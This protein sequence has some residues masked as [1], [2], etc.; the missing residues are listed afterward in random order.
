MHK[1]IKGVLF[2]TIFFGVAAIA[3]AE[4][5]ASVQTGGSTASGSAIPP[6]PEL[7]INNFYNFAMLIGGVL[8]FGMIVY[9]AL[10]YTFAAGSAS[11][12]SD[13]RDQITQAILGLLLL[14]GT[15]IVLNLINPQL[16]KGRLPTLQQIQAPIEATPGAQLLGLTATCDNTPLCE[17]KDS[18]GVTNLK[19]CLQANG[20]LPATVTTWQGS[21]RQNSCHFGGIGCKSKGSVA[22]D[23]G[24]NAISGMS[25]IDKQT[26][27]RTEL[28]LARMSAFAETCGTA[29]DKQVQCYCETPTG[30]RVSCDTSIANHVHCNVDNQPCGCN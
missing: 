14:V 19:S 1:L 3:F 27:V 20:V 8:A 2:T 5:Q 17:K 9:A 21:H 7:I 11:I 10:R 26:G 15:V 6:T 24:R 23:F 4:G 29:I 22:I 28:T 18:V 30:A 13:A 12:Q 25:Y 16:A